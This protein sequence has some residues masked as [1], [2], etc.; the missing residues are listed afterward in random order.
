MIKAIVKGKIT[1]LQQSLSL[2]TDEG[3]PLQL[4]VWKTEIFLSLLRGCDHLTLVISSIIIS[5]NDNAKKT[6]KTRRTKPCTQYRAFFQKYTHC[7]EVDSGVDRKAVTLTTCGLCALPGGVSS[8]W[9]THAAFVWR[10]VL[11]AIDVRCHSI[12]SRTS[13][14]ENEITVTFQRDQLTSGALEKASLLAPMFVF[15]L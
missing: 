10:W 3:I 11:W 13:V 9:W 7:R 8:L 1:L 15:H 5:L 14:C 2:R 12:Y 6:N 4:L